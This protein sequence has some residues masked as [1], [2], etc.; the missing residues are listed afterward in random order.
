MG[1]FIEA[2]GKAMIVGGTREIC[3]KL[4]TAIVTLRPDWH[5]DE[6]DKGVIKV[7]YSGS[8]SDVPAASRFLAAFC[9]ALS[10]RLMAL[11]VRKAFRPESASAAGS[12][13]RTSIRR[14]AATGW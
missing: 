7:V 4:Y 3:A 2:P 1:K 10:R 13:D 11:P 12:V 9:R 6:L 5:S 8:A 14:T